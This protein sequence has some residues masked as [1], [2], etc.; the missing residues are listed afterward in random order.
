VSRFPISNSHIIFNLNII[1]IGTGNVDPYLQACYSYVNYWANTPDKIWQERCCCPSFII[2][3]AGPWM[4]ISG[5]IF[6]GKPVMD[7]LIP[8][9]ALMPT[10]DVN[11]KKLVA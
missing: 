8:Y 10:M 7:P 1:Y 3:V 4:M 6:P 9:I 5:A 11:T 2:S